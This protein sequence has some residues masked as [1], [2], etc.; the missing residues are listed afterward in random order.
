M[1][2]KLD[3]LLHKNTSA[4]KL[5]QVT[6]AVYENERLTNSVF[7]RVCYIDRKLPVESVRMLPAIHSVKMT[8]CWSVSFMYCSVF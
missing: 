1:F 7:V 8:V 3:S 4:G 6:N 2:L 5:F